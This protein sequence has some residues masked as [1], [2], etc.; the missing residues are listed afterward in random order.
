MK[1]L[2]VTGYVFA[3]FWILDGVLGNL[4]A[5]AA[6]LCLLAFTL[7]STNAWGLRAYVPLFNSDQTLRR[8]S[9]YAALIIATLTATAILPTQ[10]PDQQRAQAQADAAATATA[11][12]AQ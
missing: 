12:R 10:T 3:G 1:V 8:R 5:L 6:G 7:L 9:A 11:L 2:K 4:S